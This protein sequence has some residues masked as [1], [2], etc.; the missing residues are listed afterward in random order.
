MNEIFLEEYKRLDK[1]CREIYQSEKGITSYIDDM[2]SVSAH[3]S[4][5]VPNWNP[6]LKNL[7]KL[8][9]IRNQ[10]THEVGTLNVSMCTQSDIDWLKE[11]YNRI[12]NTKDPLS[13][14]TKQINHKRN[15]SAEREAPTSKHH[16]TKKASGCLISLL[17][18]ATFVS[19]I[20]L[21]LTVV[22]S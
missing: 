12:L 13:L 15:L 8:R 21:I 7:I 20:A 18:V 9:H 3:K 22:N 1:L 19:V 4:I 11:F 5:Y 2:K 14:L 16:K 6:D 10:L 17:I